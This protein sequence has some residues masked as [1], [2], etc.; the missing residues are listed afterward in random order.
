MKLGL[1][2]AKGLLLGALV[3]LALFS[4]GGVLVRST[5]A[6][7]VIET[8]GPFAALMKAIRPTLPPL[9]F[10]VALVDVLAGAALGA[11]A[12]ALAA[13]WRPRRFWLLL[14]VE[15]LGLWLLLAWGHAIA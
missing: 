1:S 15:L 3:G 14:S 11:V 4:L 13:L 6:G 10:R 2:V 7:L 8:E 9:L 5:S 12:G